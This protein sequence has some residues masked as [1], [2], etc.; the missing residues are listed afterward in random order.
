MCGKLFLFKQSLRR[1]EST[2]HTELDKLLKCDFCEKRF[3]VN[4]LLS[5]HRIRIHTGEKRYECKHCSKRFYSLKDHNEHLR[6]H[7][8]EK[9]FKCDI[10]GVCYALK[11]TLKIHQ[12]THSG[13]KQ[14]N[15]MQEMFHTKWKF[16]NT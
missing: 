8:G 14:Y 12:E 10:C 15:I 9:P 6:I 7:T 3:T 11:K 1:H 5:Q 4:W 13:E 16:K 2:Q